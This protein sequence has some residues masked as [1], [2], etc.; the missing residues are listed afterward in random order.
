MKITKDIEQ[1]IE[2]LEAKQTE[3]ADAS[4]MECVVRHVAENRINFIARELVAL[5]EEMQSIGARAWPL[6]IELEAEGVQLPPELR[7]TFASLHQ[8][9]TTTIN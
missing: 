7:A 4:E 9:E 8:P 2:D 1:E 6:V 3:E 5:A